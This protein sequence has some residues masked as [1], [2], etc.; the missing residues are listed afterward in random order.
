MSWPGYKQAGYEKIVRIAFPKDHFAALLK[1][2]DWEWANVFHEAL[3]EIA[4]VTQVENELSIRRACDAALVAVRKKILDAYAHPS[5]EPGAA[6]AHLSS[7]PCK[8]LVAYTYG[9]K[10]FFYTMDLVGA[11]PSRV[12]HKFAA[13]GSGSELASYFLT[14]LPVGDLDFATAYAAS[15]YVIEQCINHAEG[16]GAPITAYTITKF[17]KWAQ[18]GTELSDQFREASK[19]LDAEHF[20]SLGDKLYKA[21]PQ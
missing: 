10:P 6:V 8:F 7:R 1:A 2:G 11:V 20:K 9:E 15:V 14:N 19:K 18:F 21:M 16:C 4:A 13:I 12:F 5:I 3:V 17:G